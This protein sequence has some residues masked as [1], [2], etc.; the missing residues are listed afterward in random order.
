[1]NHLI[2]VLAAGNG[3]IALIES[4]GGEAER[5]VS[6]RTLLTHAG[7][8]GAAMPSH[9]LHRGDC[10]AVVSRR[11]SVQISA[12]LAAVVNGLVVQLIDPALP[13]AA[14][15]MLTGQ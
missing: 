4:L 1:M 3:N 11:P 14:R 12:L 8:L 9:G 5:S 2:N 10:V 7:A 6:Y 13:L 15:R